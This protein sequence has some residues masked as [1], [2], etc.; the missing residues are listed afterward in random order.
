VNEL[1]EEE[2]SAGE[3]SISTPQSTS[4]L[5]S[6]ESLSKDHMADQG[7]NDAEDE[8]SSHED[9]VNVVGLNCALLSL[10]KD[11]ESS[12]EKIFLVSSLVQFFIGNSVH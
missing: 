5:G 4:M 11:E 9:N 7:S 6:V 1:D 8:E 3:N 12:V 2:P 10:I